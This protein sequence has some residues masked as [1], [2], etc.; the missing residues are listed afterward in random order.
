MRS[1]DGDVRTRLGRG[2]KATRIISY[3]SLNTAQTLWHASRK[4]EGAFPGRQVSESNTPSQGND[5]RL[6]TRKKPKAQ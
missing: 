6:L 4:A 3:L 2:V 1:V 5:L